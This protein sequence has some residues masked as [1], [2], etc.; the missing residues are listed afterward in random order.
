VFYFKRTLREAALRHKMYATFMAKPMANEP[1]SAMHITK[2]RRAPHRAQHLSNT[3]G[4]PSDAFRQLQ[5]GGLQKYL[6]AAMAFL[7]A[8]TAKAESGRSHPAPLRN[9]N[10]GALR[11]PTGAPEVCS[12]RGG[13]LLRPLCPRQ[14]QDRTYSTSTRGS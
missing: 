3:D 7:R 14:K 1:G 4:S 12:W 5:F 8:V 10:R 2:H 13:G 6:P 11:R 9:K